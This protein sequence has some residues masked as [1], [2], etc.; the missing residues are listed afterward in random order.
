[1]R[2]PF[3]RTV[4]TP[5]STS[6]NVL[7]LPVPILNATK[8]NGTVS[9]EARATAAELLANFTQ[10]L[11]NAYTFFF[12]TYDQ[13]DSIIVYDRVILTVLTTLDK[14]YFNQRRK[15][16]LEEA[17]NTITFIL[18]GHATYR[19]QYD[20]LKYSGIRQLLFDLIDLK[21]NVLG[22]F[23]QKNI[24]P[25][26]YNEKHLRVLLQ[27]FSWNASGRLLSQHELDQKL[28]E[29]AAMEKEKENEKL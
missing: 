9:D 22:L 5:T 17:K 2:S 29:V 12:E 19:R 11:D 21:K 23:G 16:L 20:F 13:V 6:T 10:K 1:M 27:Y 14:N 18:E 8:F 7:R 28:T 25:S 24:N 26:R 4:K 15:E 3:S